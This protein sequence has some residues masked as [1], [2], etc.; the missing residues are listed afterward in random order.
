MKNILAVRL[1]SLGDIVLTQ[2]VLEQIARQGHHVDL[3]VHPDYAALG[4]MLPGVQEVVTSL[5]DLKPVYDIVL[6][7]HGTWRARRLLRKVR[8]RRIV[9]YH[10]RALARRLLV[11]RGGKPRFWN[12]VSGLSE[13]EQVTDWYAQAAVRAGFAKATGWPRV[14][15]S[16]WAQAAALQTLHKA[17]CKNSGRFAVLA[18][19]ATWPTK[20][21][22]QEYFAQLA[23]G[24]EQ[25]FGYV[26]VLVG[27]LEERPLCEAVAKA[28]GGRTISLAGMTN[29]QT[30]AAVLSRAE[31]TVANDSGPLHLALAA[32]CR[33]VAL[34][35]PTVPQF[36]FAPVQHPQ[37]MVLEKKLSCRPCAVHG[38]KKCPLQHHACL[39][40]LMPQE[41]QSALKAFLGSTPKRRPAD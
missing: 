8:Y 12:A 41:V 2:P 26:P 10:K 23:L 33:A 22:P 39:R 5:S 16:E 25:K 29:I 3:M 28:A 21:W 38:G 17:G 7:L 18:P 13:K 11:R 30:L 40:T 36:G 6:D 24:L 9:H 32:G 14:E 35:G 4:R 19:G 34:F 27:V 31:I 20:Q 37:A 15:L 1:T